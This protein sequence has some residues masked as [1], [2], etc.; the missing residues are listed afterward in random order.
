MGRIFTLKGEAGKEPE[1]FRGGK[2]VAVHPNNFGKSLVKQRL[3]TE[4][5]QVAGLFWF[6]CN[7]MPIQSKLIVW[8]M[9]KSHIAPFG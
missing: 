2:S 5:L 3:P 4:D 1:E 7:S 6:A 8:H 9:I